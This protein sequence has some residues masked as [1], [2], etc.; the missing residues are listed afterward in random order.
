[1]S[2][3]LAFVCAVSAIVAAPSALEAQTTGGQP[4]FQL[5]EMFGISWPDQPIEFRYDGGQPPANTRM[6]GPGGAEVPF[7][8]VSSCSD[9]SAATCSG[10]LSAASAVIDY[11]MT[12]RFDIYFGPFWNEVKD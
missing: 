6:I 2:P 1:M 3:R 9:A 7:Q 11:K 8:W 12:K 5:T 10:T 4:S